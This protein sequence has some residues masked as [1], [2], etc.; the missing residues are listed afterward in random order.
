MHDR[1]ASIARAISPRLSATLDTFK[2]ASTWRLFIVVVKSTRNIQKCI[3]YS[4]YALT[5]S[6]EK[7]KQY[8]SRIAHIDLYQI[9]LYFPQLP[10]H[11]SVYRSHPP[12]AVSFA[13]PLRRP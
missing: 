2:Y 12:P 10:P 6:V 1:A 5:T 11:S 9:P 13:Q 4:M 8:L 3:N 7:Q